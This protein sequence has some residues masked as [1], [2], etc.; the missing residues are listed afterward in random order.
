M[1]YEAKA[2]DYYDSLTF[3]GLQVS[4]AGDQ[5]QAE[6]IRY[7]DTS[8]LYNHHHHYQ[9]HHLLVPLLEFHCYLMGLKWN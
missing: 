5:K 1:S 8:H 3:L 2:G 4:G 9:R 7:N 6:Y